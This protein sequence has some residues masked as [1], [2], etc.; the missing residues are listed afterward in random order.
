MV[1]LSSGNIRI[2]YKDREYRLLNSNR[3]QGNLRWKL[4]KRGEKKR[5]AKGKG[6]KHTL[7][8]RK[9]EEKKIFIS[10]CTLTS[11]SQNKREW[12]WV[13]KW[14]SS[15]HAD[16]VF[17]HCL[18]KKKRGNT[19]T[20]NFHTFA[21]K[22]LDL[23]CIYCRVFCLPGRKVQSTRVEFYRGGIAQGRWTSS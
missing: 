10:S 18:C 1:C 5:F 12:K 6:W 21:K 14:R 23:R 20:T 17:K 4:F 2:I 8:K 16:H 19:V 22:C 3:Y 11:T 13:I 7:Q 9:R 15:E